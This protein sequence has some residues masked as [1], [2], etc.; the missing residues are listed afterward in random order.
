MVHK[1]V[2]VEFVKELQIKVRLDKCRQDR[3]HDRTAGMQ[4]QCMKKAPFC[5]FAYEQKSEKI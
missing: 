2:G 5:L 3:E 4:V 1:N